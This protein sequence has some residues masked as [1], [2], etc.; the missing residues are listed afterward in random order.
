MRNTEHNVI[1]LNVESLLLTSIKH[2]VRLRDYEILQIRKVLQKT[3]L[4]KGK[5]NPANNKVNISI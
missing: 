5:F 2:R 4:N 3:D 1:G